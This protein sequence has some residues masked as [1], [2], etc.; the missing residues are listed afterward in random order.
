MLLITAR[1]YRGD[2]FLQAAQRLGIEVVQVIDMAHELAEFWHYPLGVDFNQPEAAVQ[3]LAEFAEKKPIDAILGIDDSGLFRM[4]PKRP[5]EPPAKIH[6]KPFACV[7]TEKYSGLSIV[8][9]SPQS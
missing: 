5:L 1:S 4:F 2:A 7:Q 8:H 3:A 9:W 6:L